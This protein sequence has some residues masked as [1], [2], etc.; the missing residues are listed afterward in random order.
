MGQI[1]ITTH[2]NQDILGYET[3]YA[4]KPPLLILSDNWGQN[5]SVL[6]LADRLGHKGFRVLALDYMKVLADNEL[7][8]NQNMARIDRVDVAEIFIP[9]ALRLLGPA[10]VLGIGFGSSLAMLASSTCREILSITSIHGLPP[11]GTVKPLKI[12][13]FIIRANKSLHDRQTLV[14]YY[15]SANPLAQVTSLV[16]DLGYLNESLPAF[17]HQR[18]RTTVDLV[19]NF[20]KKL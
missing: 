6:N 12:P 17:D 4:E 1:K 8:A 10:H 3:G 2:K 18:M 13:Q 15:T 16:V 7:A 19:T 14:D 20:I 5:Q 11:A 9:A